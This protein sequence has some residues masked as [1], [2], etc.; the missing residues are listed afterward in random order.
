MSEW[1]IVE[2]INKEE[3]KG[4]ASIR[5]SVLVEEEEMPSSIWLTEVLRGLN[6]YQ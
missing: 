6:S 5:S 4:N 1:E 2:E 3:M